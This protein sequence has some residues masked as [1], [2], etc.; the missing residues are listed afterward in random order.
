MVSKF[1]FLIFAFC[2]SLAFA[3]NTQAQADASTRDGR[4][5][6]QKEELPKSIK[7]TL[8]K[9]QIKQKQKEY[10]EMMEKGEEAVKLTEE[11]ELSFNQNNQFSNEDIKKLERLEKLVKSIRKELGGDDDEEDTD[12]PSL[13][14]QSAAGTLKEKVIGLFEELKKTSR[15]SISAIAIQ[16]SNSILRIVRFLRFGTN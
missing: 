9:A 11:L 4:P 3:A 14:L 16:G 6:P 2:F 13:S 15:H 8:L 1:L 10:D 5:N 7:E 12:K